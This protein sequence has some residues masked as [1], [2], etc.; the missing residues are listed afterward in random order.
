MKRKIY[1][2]LTIFLGILLGVIIE[3]SIEKAYINEM[4]SQ[5]TIP[6]S[7]WRNSCYLPPIVPVLFLAGGAALGYVLGVRW[8][9]IV[10]VEKR[11]WRRIKK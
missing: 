11:H 2:I 6:E 9:Q 5:G 1:I 3:A 4:L 8:W 10:Y 7:T